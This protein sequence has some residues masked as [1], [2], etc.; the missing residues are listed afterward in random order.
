MSEDKEKQVVEQTRRNHSD[1]QAMGGNL[2]KIKA[3]GGSRNYGEND[4]RSPIK[5]VAIIGGTF[6]AVVAVVY[7]IDIIASLF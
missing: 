7:L 2:Q 3:R 1:I 5:A 4:V 6:I